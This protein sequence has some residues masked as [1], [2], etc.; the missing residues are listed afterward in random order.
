M[1]DLESRINALQRDNDP[2]DND[3]RPCPVAVA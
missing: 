1:E 3:G 2:R